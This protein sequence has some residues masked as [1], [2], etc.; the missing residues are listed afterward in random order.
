MSD[1]TTEGILAFGAPARPSALR[2][3][4]TAFWRAAVPVFYG[5][6]AGGVLLLVA[7]Q[8]PAGLLLDHARERAAHLGGSGA[9]AHPAGPPAADVGGVHRGLS[10]W[11]VEHRRRRPVPHGRRHGGRP[12]PDDGERHAVLAGAHPAVHH[13]LPG[14]RRVDGRALVPQG[15]LRHERDHHLAD[16][17]L[18]RHQPRQPAH[19][20][21]VPH[22]RTP[23]SRRRTSYRSTTCCRTSPARASTSASSSRWSC[24]SWC[25]TC[26]RAPPTACAC[27]SWA[28]TPRRPSTPAST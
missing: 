24:S 25:T 16:D 22:R 17:G 3:G 26:R 18:S 7:G 14:R 4:G 8:E 10:G 19:Q 5:L 21:P 9:D 27:A 6:V 15:L 11:A 20:G 12:R 2:R 23:S 28:P 13:R 1:A